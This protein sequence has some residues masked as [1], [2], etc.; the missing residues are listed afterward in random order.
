M[1]K[2]APEQADT[3]A[4]QGWKPAPEAPSLDGGEIQI[5]RVALERRAPEVTALE[6]CLAADEEARADRFRF[7]RDRRRYV[8]TRGVLRTLLGRILDVAPAEIRL[9][10]GPEGKPSLSPAHGSGAEALQFNVAHS[11][12]VALLALAWETALGVDVEYRRELRDA[13]QIAR[14]FFSA[15]EVTSLLATP[16]E[17]RRSAFFR[18]WTRKE[19]FIKATGKG[20]SQ[21][22]GAFNV[23]TREG[24]GLQYVELDGRQTRWRLWDLPAGVE[25]GAALAVWAQNESFRLNRYRYD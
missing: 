16:A 21:P 19:A 2:M 8:V 12:E 5:W 15:Q 3:A 10:Y 17:Q 6:Q 4:W 13:E 25:Y 20:L 7:A 22:L 23:M 14:R 11:R 9:Q 18:I 24:Y 1:E